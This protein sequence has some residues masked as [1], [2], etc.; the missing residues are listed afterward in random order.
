[1]NGNMGAIRLVTSSRDPLRKSR[2]RRPATAVSMVTTRAEYPAVCA[3]CIIDVET[4]RSPT[5]YS[6]SRHGPLDA[7][8]TSSR[9]QPENVDRM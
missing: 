6:C 2:S 8:L 1:M 3:R 4:S 7:A 9:R 5:R